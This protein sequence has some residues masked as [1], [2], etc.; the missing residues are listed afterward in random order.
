MCPLYYACWFLSIYMCIIVILS[1]LSIQIINEFI[2]CWRLEFKIRKCQI[3]HSRVPLVRVDVG[4]HVAS[5]LT[6]VHCLM[7]LAIILRFHHSFLPPSRLKGMPHHQQS[8]SSTASIIMMLFGVW[9]SVNVS[10]HPEHPSL[11]I[12]NLL[13]ESRQMRL[14]YAPS[15]SI[16]FHTS[17]GSY[18]QVRFQDRVVTRQPCLE[19]VLIAALDFE[20]R[21]VDYWCDL[22]TRGS[23][24]CKCSPVHVGAGRQ[25][26][27]LVS[28]I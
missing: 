9:S 25:W 20:E 7:S 11:V 21:N 13:W 22:R 18:T 4:H 14:K 17:L 24:V 16:V 3:S 2:F 26:Y 1:G 15:F 28:L 27:T 8:S 10:T 6:L 23:I 19:F 12:T 5:Y